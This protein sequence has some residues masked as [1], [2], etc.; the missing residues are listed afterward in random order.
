[1]KKSNRFLALM[2]LMCGLLPLANAEHEST[3]DFPRLY[4]LNIGKADCMLLQYDGKTF[5]IDTGYERTYAALET[6]LAQLG[7]SYLDGIF[8]THCHQDHEGGLMQI[9]KSSI[10]IGNIYAASIYHDVKEGKHPAVL[11]A[12]ER[13]MQVI[14]LNSGDQISLN[15]HTY[16]TVLGPVTKN[17]ENE[18]NNSLV[19]HFTSPHGTMLLCG[20]M[21]TEEENDLLSRG[22]FKQADVIKCGHHGDNNA[23]SMSLLRAVKPR[24]AIILTHSG[25]EPDTP[26]PEAVTR[27]KSVGCQVYISQKYSD[28]LCIT[29]RDGT[30]SVEDILWPAIPERVKNLEGKIRL[31][32]DT[33]I[34]RNTGN[35]SVLLTGCILYST[36]G[37]DAFLLPDITLSPGQQYVFGNKKNEKADFQLDKK[38]IWHE[39]KKDVAILYDAYGRILAIADNGLKEN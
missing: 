26:S 14:F 18:N 38:S 5:L 11:A 20:D 1:M 36:K 32:N 37:D 8:L 27:L 4:C 21:K 34:L 9:A 23:T 17:I 15:E 29:L 19:L 24:H 16:F 35:E 33:F 10:G 39:K 2:L 28:A 22:L 30:V 7:I 25:E 12:K 31:S 6:A 13:G 3:D